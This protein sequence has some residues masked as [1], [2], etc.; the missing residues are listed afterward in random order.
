MTSTP[1]GSNLSPIDRLMSVKPTKRLCSIVGCKN[2]IV[3]GGLCVSH[4]AKRR[5]CQFPGCEKN[6]KSAGLCSKHGPPRKKCEQEG[7]SNVAVQGG[8]CKTHGASSKK[9]AAPGCNKIA[10]LNGMCKRHSVDPRPE[11]SVAVPPGVPPSAASFPAGMTM[12]DY[13]QMAAAQGSFAAGM[14]S[15]GWF[16]N[17]MNGMSSM[18]VANPAAFADPTMMAPQPAL[19]GYGGQFSNLYGSTGFGGMG[20]LGYGM[21]GM[22]SGN[23]MFC[24]AAGTSY[25]PTGGD[26]GVA[27]HLGPAMDMKRESNGEVESAREW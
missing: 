15:Q 26:A 25:M 24:G 20:G 4:G 19:G 5:K 27:G 11:D 8:R 17:P 1:N 21:G 9:C 10:A 14:F 6:S 13:F 18:S 22:N 7:C 3:Q 12:S 2:G 16:M 23:M